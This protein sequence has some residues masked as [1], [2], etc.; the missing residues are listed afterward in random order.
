MSSCKV[1]SPHLPEGDAK[2]H[3]NPQE[4]PSSD[5]DMELGSCGYEEKSFAT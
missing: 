4:N 1:L 3:E 5:R 2:N